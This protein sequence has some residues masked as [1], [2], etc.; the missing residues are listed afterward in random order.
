MKKKVVK[1]SYHKAQ[2]EVIHDD[3][4]NVNPFRIYY[5][6]TESTDS[7]LKRRRKQIRKY[8][9]LASCLFFLWED[10]CQNSK[11]TTESGI[12]N[13]TFRRR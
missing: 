5:L 1:V 9:D 10:V 2:Y 12:I 7:G 11:I 4:D 6:W 3:S 8:A 13:E